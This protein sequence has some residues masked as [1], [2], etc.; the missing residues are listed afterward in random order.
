MMIPLIYDCDNTMG[1]PFKEID[2]GLTLL[3][4]L[5]RPDIQL[6]GVT[7]IFGNGTTN[8]A[9]VQTQ[10]IL[11]RFNRTDVP[12]WKGQAEPGE[13]PNPAAE[14]LAQA[15]VEH[16]GEVSI[17]ATGPLTNLRAASRVDSR[18]FKHLRQIACM[19]GYLGPLRIGWRNVAELNFSADPAAAYA[20]LNAPCPVTLMSAQLCL[21]ALFGWRKLRNI[22]FLDPWIIRSV[23]N[24]LL[25][26]GLYCG[27]GK[28]YLWDL[29]PA[30]Y[31][32]H[33]DL[34]ELQQVRVV[35]M[36][37]DLAAGK[38]LVRNDKSVINRIT[39]P[40]TILDPSRFL[41]IVFEGWVAGNTGAKSD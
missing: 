10:E 9:Y 6:L 29:V 38:I 11:R 24:W 23:R 20:V 5:G 1:L 30:L 16:A 21:Q 39:L 32:S 36:E 33:P 22:Q 27:V 41:G 8:Q 35:S 14:F 17:L 18:F 31:L 34:F 26:F 19:G 40:S 28:F 13:G 37:S 4:L 25:A 7:T 2:D 15:V 3:Y 12:V